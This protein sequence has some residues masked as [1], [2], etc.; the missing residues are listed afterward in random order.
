MANTTFNKSSS[1]TMAPAGG[2]QACAMKLSTNGSGSSPEQ[3]AEILSLSMPANAEYAK[4]IFDVLSTFGEKTLTRM[5]S[6]PDTAREHITAEIQKKNRR[7]WKKSG[8]TA[9]NRSLDAEARKAIADR[10][11]WF[12]DQLSLLVPD[13]EEG[14]KSS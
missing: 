9:A 2:K 14:R 4:C 1:S 5:V 13:V 12:Q 10:R 7:N 6:K 8:K 11:R 3:A